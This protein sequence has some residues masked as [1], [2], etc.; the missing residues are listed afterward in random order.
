MSSVLLSFGAGEGKFCPDFVSTVL[1]SW[2]WEYSTRYQK[3]LAGLGIT[4]DLGGGN[5]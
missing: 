4:E 5:C 2:A 3:I 1:K